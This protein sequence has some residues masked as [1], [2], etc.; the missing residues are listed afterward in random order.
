M[1]PF[2]YEDRTRVTPLG[3]LL[4]GQRAVIEATVE[5]AE[6]AYRGRRTLLCRLADGTGALTLRFFYFSRAQQQGLERGKRV[7]C[8]GE[9]RKGPTGLEMVHPEYRV[10]AEAAPAPLED[11]LTPVYP[12]TEGVTQA[13]L[14]GLISQVLDTAGAGMPDYLPAALMHELGLPTLGD[15][16]RYLHRPPAAANL[17]ELTAGRHP[18]QRR[19]VI[20]E[21]LAHHLSLRQVRARANRLRALSL[22]TRDDSVN[23]FL[24]GLGFALTGDQQKAIDAIRA[25][26]TA[27]HPMMRLV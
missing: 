22:Q 14:R 2:R 13:R 7:R 5:L 21:L 6:V 1:L 25:D 26:V 11:T 3:G 12:A 23:R 4:P 27:D 15:A 8:Y 18:A 17:E 19:L 10:L 20:E 24:A 9:V 16:L